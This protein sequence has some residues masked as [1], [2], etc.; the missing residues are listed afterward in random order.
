[1]KKI[2]LLCFIMLCAWMGKAQTTCT[3]SATYGYP[4]NKTVTSYTNSVYW[5]NVTVGPGDFQLLVTSSSLANKITRADVYVGSCASPTL[6]A[7][8]TIFD[9]GTDSTLRI[10]ITNTTST[11]YYVQLTKMGGATTFSVTSTTFCSIV[12]DI[13]FCPG[14]SSITLAAN[15]LNPGTGPYTYT[16]NP[17]GANTSSINVSSPTPTTY[18]LTY[19]DAGGTYTTT[20]TTFTLPASVCNACEMV[21][22]G[23]FE[24]YQH[25]ANYP[26][27]IYSTPACSPPN[28]LP[29]SDPKYWVAPTCG[30]PDYYNQNFPL[31]SWV[32]VPTSTFSNG[33]G[34]SAHSGKGYAGFYTHNLPLGSVDY[35]E[36]ITEQ[37]KCPLLAGQAYNVSFYAVLA[38]GCQ[39][40]NNN[41][42]LYLSSS[43][44]SVPG[45]V[46]DMY[47]PQIN[48]NN[49]INGNGNSWQQVS[50]LYIGNGE[51][52]ATI[53]NFTHEYN[54]T[55][56][57]TGTGSYGQS[58]YFVDDI[59]ITPATPT[60]TASGCYNGS[61]TISA[62]GAPNSTVTTWAG[63]SSYTATGSS[64]T[65]T[66][67]TAAA[68]YT[69]TVNLSTS[70]ISCP[71]ITQTITIQPPT[72]CSGTAPTYTPGTS[73]TFNT[74]PGYASSN[75]QVNSGVNY[76]ISKTELR[77]AP[78]TS[79]T[80]ASGG[81]LTVQGSWLHACNEC[82]TSSMWNGITVQNGGTLIARSTGTG[83]STAYNY[84]E[85]AVI[86]VYTATSATATPIPVWNITNTM[87][88]KNTYDIVIDAHVGNLSGNVIG[89]NCIF[90]CR[91]LASHATSFLAFAVTVG[92]IAASTPLH[93]SS[94]NPTDV[95]IAGARS[96]YGIYI[97]K[98][99]YTNPIKVGSGGTSSRNIFDNHDCGIYAYESSLTAKNNY[100]INMTGNTSS[101][102]NG[103]GIYQ[104]MS[105]TFNPNGFPGTL[106]VGNSGLTIDNT[107]KNYFTNCLRGI[108]TYKL[109]DA[110]IN[111]N[112][113]D[114]ETTATNFTTGKVTGQYGVV[115]TG[116]GKGSSTGYGENMQY[117]NNTCNN[118]YC[119]HFYDFSKVFNTSS[120][121]T[122]FYN[123]VIGATGTN[124]CTY[125]LY[126]QGGSGSDA[127]V[128]QDAVSIT[129]NSITNVSTNCVNI[130][131]VTT[132]TATT[133]YVTV[134]NNTELS[135]K[136]STVGTATT[137]PPIAAVYL[138]GDNYV[139]V[140]NNA[141]IK[142]T[143]GIGN[144]S[145][146]A[147]QYLAGVYVNQ[148]T[149]SRVTCNTTTQL[150]EDFVW[151][152]NSASSF[153]KENNMRSS[154][155]GLVLR[156]TGV[157]GDQGSASN[158]IY[159]I[160]GKY[161][162]FGDLCLGQTLCDASN[163]GTGTTSKLYCL[164]STCSSATTPM[165]CTNQTA[166]AGTAYVSPTTLIT[167]TGS[168]PGL[169]TSEGGNGRMSADEPKSE[170][171]LRSL[172][173][174]NDKLPAYTDETYWAT[175]YHVSSENNS[176]EA[177]RG[178]EN[179]RTFAAV[180]GA[181]TAG[182][183]QKAQSMLAGITPI[184]T[185]EKNWKAVDE[186]Q[187]KLETISL[188]QLSGVEINSLKDVAAQCP[189]SG[190]AIVFRARAIL[191]AHNKGIIE[192]KNDCPAIDK[193]TQ[194]HENS[195]AANNLG[196]SV[197][198]NPTDGKLYL[199]N[200]AGNEKYVLVEVMDITGSL[201]KKEQLPVSNNQAMLELNLSNGVYLVRITGSTARGEVHK[202]IFN[203]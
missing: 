134:A 203:R 196:V 14:V 173:N 164:A 182:D 76:T 180:D 142:C 34:T 199:S 31:S 41:I 61:V 19:H 26:F 79:I 10:P 136:Y 166:N 188:E 193:A 150:G 176:I 194:V 152:G 190:G 162:S 186:I 191:N 97:N 168:S 20:I 139:K 1:M 37:I 133:G 105:N 141:V 23:H 44:I 5:F 86:A 181:L 189:M 13:G 153:W 72:P 115:Q 117:A 116:F 157:L 24:S 130:T 127:G 84:I 78:G 161:S 32:G 65:V 17:T 177:V 183:I 109:H 197:Y 15:V 195:I 125:G 114:N 187:L 46:L 30:S 87:F 74:S 11:T 25:Q 94:A 57:S 104:D 137:S 170:T 16:W 107:E 12:G 21:Q 110:Y 69:C 184:N 39:Y 106:I 47:T 9:T 165:P 60:L 101:F 151:Y 49:V 146:Y 52:Y 128:P 35:R 28:G 99:L 90:T 64:I 27:N 175:Q 42:G 169:C 122:Y 3:T 54:T 112:V 201:V 132:G 102:P 163:P 40:Y 71:N 145:P 63:P 82:S 140:S 178:Y 135:L 53:G 143:N 96:S 126:L 138:S 202:I 108:Q 113:F 2:I 80:V 4:V 156:S 62:Y 144:Y 103:I 83:F 77:M 33:T 148:S 51:Q 92:D 154:Q 129:T 55:T 118:Y 95:T 119:G 43:A 29:M 198:P 179:A 7:T 160:W 159:D 36:Y 50:G 70:C 18:T 121:G 192:Y 172:L 167:T 8:D 149:N 75:I 91:N 6:C 120:N 68:T 85:D 124:Y 66:S 200:F 100:F 67:P 147:A 155:Y 111:N 56:T 93:P 22:N 81:T 131:G 158:P 73:Y 58:Y 59:S 45:G 89:G 185:V 98:V 48:A 88:N 38:N 171:Y 174:F 123:N